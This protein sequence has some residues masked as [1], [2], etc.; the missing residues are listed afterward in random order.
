[1]HDDG[2]VTKNSLWKPFYSGIMISDI[3][4]H[5]CRLDLQLYPH[6]GERC[7]E[8]ISPQNPTGC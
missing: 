5:V 1:M 2:Q 7:S 6:D 3:I 4:L 8:K